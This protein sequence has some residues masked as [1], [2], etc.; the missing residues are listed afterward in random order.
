MAIGVITFCQDSFGPSHLLISV[1]TAAMKSGY[2]TL[3]ASVPEPTV[4]AIKRAADD[5]RAHGVEGIILNVPTAVNLTSLQAAFGSTPCVVTD[6]G[7][8]SEIT[9]VTTDHEYGACIG[10]EHLIELGHR[11]I[12]CLGPQVIFAGLVHYSARGICRWC[13]FGYGKSFYFDLL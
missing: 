8:G 10:T 2:N 3:L 6:A 9:M 1:D 4:S 12:A 7:A 11:M 5:L 13:L